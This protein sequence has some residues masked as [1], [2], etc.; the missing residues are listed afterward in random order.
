MLPTCKRQEATWSSDP[1]TLLG[2]EAPRRSVSVHLIPP[3]EGDFYGVHGG[4]GNNLHHHSG[5]IPLLW[6]DAQGP[7]RHHERHLDLRRAL[8]PADIQLRLALGQDGGG[9]EE[10]EKEKKE[11]KSEVVHDFSCAR[12]KASSRALVEKNAS[13]EKFKEQKSKSYFFIFVKPPFSLMSNTIWHSYRGIHACSTFHHSYKKENKIVFFFTFVLSLGIEPRSSVPQTDVLSIE[14]Q[15]RAKS[16]PN[17]TGFVNIFSEY[18]TFF[19]FAHLRVLLLF[20][21]FLGDI[22]IIVLLTLPHPHH[23]YQAVL[24]DA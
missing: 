13:P 12:Y 3:C 4:G 20:Q 19:A 8:S 1:S 24:L 10:E 14:L 5:G 9:G 21:N 2:D 22:V 16:I 6:G 17:I 15:E 11:K 7:D 18:A 23:L